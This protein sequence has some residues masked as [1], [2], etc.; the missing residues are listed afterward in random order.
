MVKRVHGEWFGHVYFIF[1]E[2]AI[3]FKE[4]L[5]DGNLFPMLIGVNRLRQN[6]LKV[7]MLTADTRVGRN[8]YE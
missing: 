4:F 3:I 2:R 7:N 1:D 5:I 8:A 6:S